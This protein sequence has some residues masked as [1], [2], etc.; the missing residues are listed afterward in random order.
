MTARTP[1]IMRLFIV[2]S[3]RH[4]ASTPWS[5]HNSLLPNT[6]QFIIHLTAFHWHYPLWDTTASYKKKSIEIWIVSQVEL[7][8]GQTCFSTNTRSFPCHFHSSS[9]QCFPIN[10]SWYNRSSQTTE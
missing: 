8:D 10:S 1:N 2:F 4:A 3:A 9:V 5:A 7:S 6:L